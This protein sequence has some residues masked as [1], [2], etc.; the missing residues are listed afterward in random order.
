MTN[1]LWTTGDNY[2]IYFKKFKSNM[3]LPEKYRF[4]H[5]SYLTFSP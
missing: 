5:I 4:E 2:N 1:A 3:S